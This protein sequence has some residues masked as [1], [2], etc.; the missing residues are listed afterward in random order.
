V[1]FYRVTSVS[2]ACHEC[3]AHASRMYNARVTFVTR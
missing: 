2:H 1:E 3:D